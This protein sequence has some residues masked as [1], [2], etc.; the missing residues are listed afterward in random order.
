M[1]FYH[2]GTPQIMA[3]KWNVTNSSPACVAINISS[4][5]S[6]H[7]IDNRS[8]WINLTGP[9][10]SATGFSWVNFTARDNCS[11]Q[12]TN[13]VWINITNAAPTNNWGSGSVWQLGHNDGVT[14]L[15][16]GGGS[17]T[18]GDSITCSMNDTAIYYET[19]TTLK[20]NLAMGLTDI[21]VHSIEQSC[22]D[23]L[24]TT[25]ATRSVNITNTA[26][27]FS[28][29]NQ[30]YKYYV[31]QTLC[32]VTDLDNDAL[33]LTINDSM[34]K[35][36]GNSIIYIANTSAIGY[37]II[38]ANA[39]D[40]ISMSSML[41]LVNI[42]NIF[43]TRTYCGN[44]PSIKYIANTSLINA[45]T[46]KTTQS[47]FAN[48][49]LIANCT[50]AYNVPNETVNLTLWAAVNATNPGYK[51]QMSCADAVAINLTTTY[52]SIKSIVPNSS[53]KCN[54]TGYWINSN[55]ASFPVAL[56][57]RVIY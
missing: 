18:D 5:D 13:I 20:R 9:N 37:H 31:N 12:V 19:S 4:N 56:L 26:P 27:I 7:P 38:R 2:N 8:G 50:L 3:V 14:A 49:T 54:L 43:V 52:Q 30:S 41:F 46:G 44:I 16:G 28:C 42:T 21:G 32:N 40:S 1:E 6:A 51:V 25:D 17:D 34:F 29:S 55:N 11:N 57:S 45:T 39:T 36:S 48:G 24:A 15:G 22:T 10:I 35:V 53:L 23:G 33:T 47:V